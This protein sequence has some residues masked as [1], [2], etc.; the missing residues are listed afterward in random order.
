MNGNPEAPW[1]I[2]FL[3]FFEWDFFSRSQLPYNIYKV[4]YITHQADLSNISEELL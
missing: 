2:F 4:F 1:G 3:T